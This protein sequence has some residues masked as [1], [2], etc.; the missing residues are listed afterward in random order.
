MFKKIRLKTYKNIIVIINLFL[1]LFCGSFV[2]A[3][4]FSTQPSIKQ[5]VAFI[6]TSGYDPYI[7]VAEIISLV[8]KSFL[9]LLGI[10]FVILIILG[11]YNWMTAA[12]EEEKVN[13]AKDT[14]KR[15]IIGLIIVVSAYAIT[16]FVF[17]NLPGGGTSPG[18]LGGS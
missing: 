6:K 7:S 4:P 8:I 15:A 17:T 10:I 9:G 11:G 16:Y 14:L 18:G 1:L 13:K 2:Y 5:D 12:G 3:G